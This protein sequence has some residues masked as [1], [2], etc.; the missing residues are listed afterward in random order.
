MPTRFPRIGIAPLAHIEYG[1]GQSWTWSAHV[2]LGVHGDLSRMAQGS[3]ACVRSVLRTPACAHCACCHRGRRLVR[4]AP[5]IYCPYGAGVFSAPN[6]TIAIPPAGTASYANSVTCEYRITTGA[7]IYLRFDT[8]ATEAKFDYV[9]VYDGTSATGTLLGNFSG[10]AIPAIQT[11]TSGSM[12]IRFTSD[13]SGE[14]A[15]V[16]MTWLD[17]MPVTLAPTRTPTLAPNVAGGS[18]EP[19]AV[20]VASASH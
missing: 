18:G 8:F 4:A 14:A 10:A 16:S 12:L 9:Y 19:C 2:Q 5:T 15:G 13:S 3:G 17:V 1:R 20:A 7:P 6:G 11:A